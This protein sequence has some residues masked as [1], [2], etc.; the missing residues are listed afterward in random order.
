MFG[1]VH[2]ALVAPLIAQLRKAKLRLRPLGG[3][4]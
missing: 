3:S 4:G 2:Q 1:D